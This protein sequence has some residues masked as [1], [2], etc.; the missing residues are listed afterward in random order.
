MRGHKE[1]LLDV[2]WLPRG[3]SYSYVALMC[4]F[5]PPPVAATFIY[6]QF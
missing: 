5:V 2:H 4:L 1:A 6:F 3:L